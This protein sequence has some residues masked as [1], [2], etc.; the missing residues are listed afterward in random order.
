LRAIGISYA[1]R[2]LERFGFVSSRMPHSLSLALG[3]GL[4]TPLQMASAYAVFANGG[5]RVRAHFIREIAD[6]NTHQ[7]LFVSNPA[8][9][10][11]ACIDS[12][13]A[14]LAFSSPT[15]PLAKKVISTQ[16]AY[17]MTRALQDA[18]QRGTGRAAKTLH[19]QDLAGKTGTTNN[20]LDAWFSGFNSDLVATV[21]VGFDDSTSLQEYGAQAALPIWIDF[22]HQA[23]QDSPEHTMP[24][25]PGIIAV[26]IDPRTGL[27][28]RP[29]QS[30]AI[31]ELFRQGRQ[32]RQFAVSAGGGGSGHDAGESEP[33]F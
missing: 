8:R 5:Y 22:M 12:P 27:L 26:R 21:W 24:E 30:R 1:I 17:L 29:N 10:C 4:V 32:P 7:M 16:N 9:A 25:P 3:T 14:E 18:I 33:L 6:E 15:A 13:L 19:R 28:A 31:F 20:K 2:Y 11:E 23:L